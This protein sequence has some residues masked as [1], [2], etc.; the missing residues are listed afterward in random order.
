[1]RTV[2]FSRLTHGDPAE[3]EL[4]LA[5]SVEDGFFYL[6]LQ[7]NETVQL[8]EDMNRLMD[9]GRELFD[10]PLKEKLVHD[11]DTLGPYKLDGYV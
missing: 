2:S 11:I 9:V 7:G 5:S 10:L 4:L 8:L 3:V 1:M 6:D